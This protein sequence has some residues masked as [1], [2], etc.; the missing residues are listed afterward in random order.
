MLS[1][2]GEGENELPD[3]LCKDEQFVSIGTGTHL[4]NITVDCATL[5]IALGE[6]CTGAAPPS[7]GV[8]GSAGTY[9]FC[10]VAT[11][12]SFAR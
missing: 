12:T 3:P 10:P 9:D 6:G 7:S 1:A 8:S 4:R 2:A 11:G 5:K